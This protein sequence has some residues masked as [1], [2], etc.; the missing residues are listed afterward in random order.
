MA[1]GLAKRGVLR[2][3]DVLRRTATDT[4]AITAYYDSYVLLFLTSYAN[5]HVSPMSQMQW[6]LVFLALILATSTFHLL[7]HIYMFQ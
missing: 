6:F 7:D 1:D 3:A 5:I 2:G 4:K